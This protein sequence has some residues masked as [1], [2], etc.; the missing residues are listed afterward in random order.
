MLY[1]IIMPLAD[2]CLT[3]SKTILEY[4]SLYHRKLSDKRGFLLLD[5]NL[6]NGTIL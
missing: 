4:Y 3:H 5:R 2:A 1:K 6:I